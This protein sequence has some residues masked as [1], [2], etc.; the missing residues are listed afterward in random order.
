MNSFQKSNGHDACST[1]QLLL[2]GC[3]FVLASCVLSLA[4]VSHLTL[5]KN[6]GCGHKARCQNAERSCCCVPGMQLRVGLD[7]A[8]KSKPLLLPRWPV[9]VKAH[10]AG[11]TGSSHIS[12]RR[13]HR[14]ERV[15]LNDTLAL[16]AVV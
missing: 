16:T 4:R 15:E 8:R 13:V 7:T 3:L 1:S 2:V 14:F 11:Q 12:L 5:C 10:L 9:G 6:L